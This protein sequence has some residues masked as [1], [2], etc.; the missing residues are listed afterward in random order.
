MTT[1]RD[2]LGVSPTAD[3][4]QIK[5]A[6]RKMAQK[7]HPDRNPDDPKAEEKFKEGKEAYEGLNEGFETKE[8][9]DRAKRPRVQRGP[10]EPMENFQDFIRQFHQGFGGG[11]AGFQSTLNE[12]SVP[13][14]VMYSGGN[15]QFQSMAQARQGNTVMF[16]PVMHTINIPANSKVG[17]KIDFTIGG[18]D[19]VGVLFPESSNKY[20]VDG[21]DIGISH[22][23]DVLDLIIGTK[24]TIKH[25]NGKPI[26]VTIKPIANHDSLIR[27]KGKGLEDTFGMYGDFFVQLM[28][29]VP[30]FNEEQQKILKEAVDK[31]RK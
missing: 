24:I 18:K 29:I 16:R 3:K 23:I 6:Y 10:A 5:A 13:V 22:P 17:Q 7:Y 26:R 21:L 1:Y 27:L 9:Q 25:P 8:Q 15:V 14:E 30:E 28:P 11:N 2:I 4:D 20:T 12:M 19:K 31:I